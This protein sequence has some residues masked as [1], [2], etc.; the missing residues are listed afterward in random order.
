MTES[1]PTH[2]I[3][4]ITLIL[5]LSACTNNAVQ[6]PTSAP[7]V[8]PSEQATMVPTVTFTIIP[9]STA[10]PVPSATPTAEPTSTTAP[11]ATIT[12]TELSL[13]SVIS[14][15]GLVSLSGKSDKPFPTTVVLRLGGGEYGDEGA[16]GDEVVSTIKTDLDGKY[17]FSD[18]KPGIYT[19]WVLI[20]A[21]RAMIPGCDEIL[22][23][24]TGWALGLIFG[25]DKSMISWKTTSL[26]WGILFAENLPADMQPEGFYAVSPAL[27]IASGTAK[28][29]NIALICK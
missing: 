17:L 11:T 24:G 5:L 2:K 13:S 25:G 16:R 6:P 27:E 20:T 4:I 26:R 10:T 29:Q 1:R 7:V 12:P 3:L 14:I 9:T 22:Q 23:P 18:L 28:T 8:L 19:I 15:T 21:K